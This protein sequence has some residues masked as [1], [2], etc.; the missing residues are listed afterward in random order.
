[1]VDNG[2]LLSRAAP[3][4]DFSPPTCTRYHYQQQQKEIAIVARLLS[5]IAEL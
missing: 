1:V 3:A 2:A 5:R 4:L